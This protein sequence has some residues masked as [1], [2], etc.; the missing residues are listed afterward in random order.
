MQTLSAMENQHFGKAQLSFR[1]RNICYPKDQECRERKLGYSERSLDTETGTFRDGL[2]EM[3][4][5]KPAWIPAD[6]LVSSNISTSQLEKES[7]EKL[8]LD[9]DSLSFIKEDEDSASDLSDSE[10]ILIPPSPRSPPE[11]NLQAEKIEPGYFDHCFAED[12]D[13]NFPDFLPPPFNSWNLPHLATFVNREGKPILPT[14]ASG[15]LERYI[16]RLL[17]LEWLQIQTVQTE[18]LKSSKLRPQTATGMP[19]KSPGKIKPLHTPLRIKETT[20]AEH[21]KST[22]ARENRCNKGNFHHDVL[23]AERFTR[24]SAIEGL[25]FARKQDVRVKKRPVMSFPQKKV[26]PTLETNSKIQSIGNVR[27]QKQAQFSHGTES[28]SK[29][30]KCSLSSNLRSNRLSSSNHALSAP[31]EAELKF[32]VR[33]VRVSSCKGKPI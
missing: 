24:S 31:S 18:K 12:G 8:F 15:F 7:S 13:Y 25:S 3:A 30:F 20:V 6:R 21:V 28:T 17:Q 16:D 23:A 19:A 1:T 10:R 32:K 22:D 29:L 2:Q 26:L 33:S 14:T 11:L 27:P 5:P 4:Q 9:F